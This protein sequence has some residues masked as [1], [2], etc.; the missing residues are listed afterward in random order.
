MK[1]GLKVGSIQFCHNRKKNIKNTRDQ[2]VSYYEKVFEIVVYLGRSG[3]FTKIRFNNVMA[4]FT[5]SDLWRE[6]N[7]SNVYFSL[8]YP[9]LYCA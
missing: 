5:V 2:D 4:T 1:P 9:N 7:I 8:L 6:L 3:S